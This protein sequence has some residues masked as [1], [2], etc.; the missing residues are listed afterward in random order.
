MEVVNFA[1][2]GE[3]LFYLLR[4]CFW[5]A[6]V[7]RVWSFARTMIIG[8]WGLQGFGAFE[9]PSGIVIVGVHEM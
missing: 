9:A 5:F 4:F 2:G 1:S 3:G 8:M 7:Q 6:L